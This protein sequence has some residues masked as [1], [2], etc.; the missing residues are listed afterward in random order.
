MCNIKDRVKSLESQCHKHTNTLA[1]ML[2]C[3]QYECHLCFSYRLYPMLPLS[4]PAL[5][6]FTIG[7]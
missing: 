1:T 2:P 7:F 6:N 4:F 5:V 3:Q